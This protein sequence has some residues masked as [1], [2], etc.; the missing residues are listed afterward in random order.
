[1]TLWFRL[2]PI[3]E[4]IWTFVCY[5]DCS[6][7][8][9]PHHLIRRDFVSFSLRAIF[10]HMN[11]KNIHTSPHHSVGRLINTLS[12]WLNDTDNLNGKLILSFESRP[13]WSMKRR[14]AGIIIHICSLWN[15]TFANLAVK[16]TITTSI[17]VIVQANKTINPIRLHDALKRHFTSLKTHLVFLQLGVLEYKFPWNCFTHTWQLFSFIFY[18][19]HVIFIHY[20]SRIAAAIRGL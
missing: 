18:P 10:A 15:Q 8:S 4:D 14:L 20:K 9:V 3:F 6:L 11:K 5:A 16:K 1:M 19:L 13:V 17:S 2:Q 7:K 12:H